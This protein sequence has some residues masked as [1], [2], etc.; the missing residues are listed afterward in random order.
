MAV[1]NLARD[2][3]TLVKA[4]GTVIREG[5]KAQVSPGQII[6]FETDV[7]L[8]PGDHF[9]RVLP[10][11]LAEDYVV[12]DPGYHAGL[13]VIPAS[14]QAQV[15]R[16]D[17]PAAPAQTVINNITNNVHGPNSRVNI[18]STDNSTNS[19][20]NVSTLRLAQLLE[21]VKPHI[22]NL[23]EP[24]RSEIVA[25]IDLLEGEVRSGKLNQSKVRTALTSIKTIVEG[26]AGNLVASGIGALVGN[27][28][29][30]S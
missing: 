14:Y 10:N 15:R 26:A 11:K 9:I 23:P 27:M 25:P 22:G 2:K 16:S 8:E 24:Q 4:D 5:M 21:E 20:V 13:S 28:L 18:N 7:Q 30:G 1:G 3:V 29:A 17:A 6:T 12:I 19:A